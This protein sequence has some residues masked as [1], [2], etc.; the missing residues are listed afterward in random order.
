[1]SQGDGALVVLG[2]FQAVVDT[3]AYE[4]KILN[5]LDEHIPFWDK[6]LELIFLSHSDKDHDGAL[7]GVRKHYKVGKVIRETN[8]K[9]VIRYGMLDFEILKG[10]KII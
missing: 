7:E 9:D 10:A 5:C 1:M 6:K 4:E 3:G 2:N 8:I